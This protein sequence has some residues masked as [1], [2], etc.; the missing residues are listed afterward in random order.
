MGLLKHFRSKSKLKDSHAASHHH[1]YPAYPPVQRGADITERLPDDVVKKIL[2]FVCPHAFD[3][4][5]QTSERS[6][7]G[8]GCMLCDMRDLARC[9]LIRKK[10]YALASQVQYGSIR[11]DAVHYCELEDVLTDKRRRKSHR[12][13]QLDIPAV[14]LELLA[15]T[16]RGNNWL[17]AAVKVIKLPY[18]T[19]ET[20]RTQIAQTVSVLP[21]LRYIDLPDGF[22]NGEASCSTLRQEVQINCPDI[23]KM[24]Y[25]FGAEKMFEML[26][27]R[28][29]QSLE[30][31]EISHLKTQPSILRRV[32]AILPTLQEVKFSHLSWLND[33]I[34][35]STPALPDFPPLHS[36]V[37]EK[38]PIT[39]TGLTTYL[40]RPECREVLT[41]LSLTQTPVSISELH[42]VIWMAPQIRSLTIATRVTEPLPLEPLPA[43]ASL[44][45]KVLHY[46]ITSRETDRA[47]ATDHLAPG[48]CDG[49]YAYLTNSLLNNSLPALRQVYVRDPDFPDSLVDLA[50]APPHLPF[51]SSPTSSLSSPQFRGFDQPLEVFAKGIAEHDWVY[52]SVLPSSPGP[53]GRRGSMTGGRPLSSYS[54]SRGLGP[55]W[56]R[57]GERK[58][59]VVGNGFGGFLA[60]PSEEARPGS[61]GGY[62]SGGEDARAGAQLSPIRATFNRLSIGSGGAHKEKRASRADLWR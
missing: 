2:Y 14:R 7:V 22:F 53:Q 47:L 41:N 58:S 15:R 31:L 40:S 48:P 19:R 6:E 28:H 21:N 52:T 36:L 4:T 49:Y 61:S 16:L 10:W 30:Y 29:W 32:L 33:S 24:R 57:E 39:A 9:S 11:I 3:E 56:N 18:M 55:Q 42:S 25:E 45:L 26:L 12:G 17:A 60:V 13:E 5:Y 37:I 51:S 43:L 23:R 44:S 46:E 50:L 62:G 35:Q 38:C 20:C 59:I 34:F 54:A 1:H 27:Q 8:D